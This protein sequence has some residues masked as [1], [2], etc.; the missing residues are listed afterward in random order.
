MATQPTPFEQAILGRIAADHP[1]LLPLIAELCV[2]RR[3]FSGA[4]SFTYF[5]PH[6]AV[7]LPDG[8][9][10]LRSLIHM[11]GV[12]GG[13]GASL[14]VSSGRVEALEIYTFGTAS[15]AGRF[16]GFVIDDAA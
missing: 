13:M 14:A 7:A 16:D 3:E 5:Q 11:P 12:E 4:G 1:L 8:Y 6:P 10:G 2:D 9:I 15:W